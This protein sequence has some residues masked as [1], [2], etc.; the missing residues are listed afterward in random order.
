[1]RNNI[2]VWKKNTKEQ[3]QQI[4]SHWGDW[5]S[6]HADYDNFIKERLKELDPEFVE[7]LDL[8]TSGAKFWYA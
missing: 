4:K 6:V 7:D 1:V 3:K 5:E 2:I 8:A